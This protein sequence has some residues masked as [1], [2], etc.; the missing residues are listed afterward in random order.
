MLAPHDLAQPWTGAQRFG[1]WVARYLD[2]G[3][4]DHYAHA[5]AY[6]QLATKSKALKGAIPGRIIRF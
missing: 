6:C 1:N 4:P 3:K 5:E 2:H